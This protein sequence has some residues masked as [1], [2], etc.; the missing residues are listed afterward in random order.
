MYSTVSMDE[1]NSS[2]SKRMASTNEWLA[3]NAGPVL[4]ALLEDAVKERP[5]DFKSWLCKKLQ[6]EELDRSQTLEK[7]QTVQAKDKSYII[8]EEQ[9]VKGKVALITGASSGIGYLAAK[10]FANKV[11]LVCCPLLCLFLLALFL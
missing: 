6:T 10:L 5:A 4:R 2:R 11:K 7:G 1:T 8:G 9:E 3:M